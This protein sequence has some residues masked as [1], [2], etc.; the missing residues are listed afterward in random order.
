[1][2]IST[3]RISKLD[4]ARRQLRTAIT[5]WFNNGD[6]VSVYALAFAA[7]EI[8]HMVSVKRDPHRRELFFDTSIIKDEYRREWRG[9][10]RREANFFKHGDRDP[11]AVIDFNPEMSQWF[12]FF[13][14]L[15]RESCGESASLE[16]RLFIFGSKSIGLTSSRKRGKISLKTAFKSKLSITFEHSLGANFSKHSANGSAAFPSKGRAFRLDRLSNRE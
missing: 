14:I 2:N 13:S 1:M 11:E 5:L 4:A 9:H 6:P 15:G 7:Y 12:I 16:N 3:I 8:F 10:I